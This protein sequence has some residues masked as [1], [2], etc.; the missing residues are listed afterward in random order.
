MKNHC[1]LY[2]NKELKKIHFPGESKP[3]FQKAR[4]RGNLTAS[5]LPVKEKAQENC[6]KSA[7]SAANKHYF[8]MIMQKRVQT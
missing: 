1:F 4:E 8:A 5:P 6:I 3:L 2:K 7:E